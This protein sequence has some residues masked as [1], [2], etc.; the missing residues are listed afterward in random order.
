MKWFC[1][2]LSLVLIVAASLASAE[3]PSV[4]LEIHK[5]DKLPAPLEKIAF[6]KSDFE[7]DKLFHVQKL[8]FGPAGFLGEDAVIL[9]IQANRAITYRHLEIYLRQFRDVRFYTRRDDYEDRF[10]HSTILVHPHTI[11][12]D[13]ANGEVLHEK[14]RV[15]VWFYLD[16]AE[17][18][19]LINFKANTVR[20]RPY[21]RTR[22][23]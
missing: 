19:K 12:A 6:D 8:R 1:C 7:K 2:L 16:R 23:S 20:F 3:T 22:A 10:V 5:S 11:S 14:A 15:D 13:A 21:K 9:T 4:K 17:I 18:Q